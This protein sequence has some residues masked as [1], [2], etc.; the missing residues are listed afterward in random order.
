MKLLKKLVAIELLLRE[1]KERGL[2][3][4][5]LA[6]MYCHNYKTVEEAQKKNDK[7]NYNFMI[8]NSNAWEITRSKYGK[9]PTKEQHLEILVELIESS[10]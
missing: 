8:W 2:N 10:S 1:A 4:Y 7:T 5:Y 3:P 9:L 6:Y